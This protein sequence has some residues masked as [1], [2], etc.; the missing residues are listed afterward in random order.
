LI[1]AHSVRG[2]S[3]SRREPTPT[4]SGSDNSRFVPLVESRLGRETGRYDCGGGEDGKK[5]GEEGF[6]CG[7]AGEGGTENQAKIYRPWNE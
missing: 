1:F 7:D 3:F 2:A 4:R 6:H 5:D